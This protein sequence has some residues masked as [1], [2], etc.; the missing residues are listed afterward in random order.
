MRACVN[1]SAYR[2]FAATEYSRNF[3]RGGK[4]GGDSNSAIKISSQVRA[5]IITKPANFPG[6]RRQWKWI[7]ISSKLSSKA[8]VQYPAY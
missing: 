7:L 4:F 8:V 2:L 1:S 3:Q 6:H 5:G